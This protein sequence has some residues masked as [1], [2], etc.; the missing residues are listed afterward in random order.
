MPKFLL[1]V[2]IPYKFALWNNSDFIHQ[3]DID[4]TWTD[5]QIWQYAKQNNL[6][7]V[8]KDSDF[9]NRILITQPPPKI[10]IFKTGNMKMKEFHNLVNKIWKQV[11]DTI[12][13]SKCVIVYPDRI[14]ILK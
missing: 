5:E 11:L 10:I 3:I 14:E 6:I 7:I 12:F 9:L 13:D 8:T 1:D 4:D 2:N